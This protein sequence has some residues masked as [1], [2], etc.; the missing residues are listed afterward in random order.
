MP[1]E[2]KAQLMRFLS[3]K[4]WCLTTRLRTCLH[5]RPCVPVAST[6]LPQRQ[7]W[8]LPSSEPSFNAT[9]KRTAS[10]SCRLASG[11]ANHCVWTKW[12]ATP[13]ASRHYVARML[14]GDM[15]VGTVIPVSYT[16][17]DSAK[18]PDL[19]HVNVLTPSS[20]WGR[21]YK[22]LF[23]DFST[24]CQT[25]WQRLGTIKYSPLSTKRR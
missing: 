13:E 3:F 9:V 22:K 6:K 20:L 8:G 15:L 10:S 4:T 5:T 24:I 16:A 21:D 2:L 25:A 1:A 11:V 18:I 7:E 12:L 19:S 14:R 23:S 17:V